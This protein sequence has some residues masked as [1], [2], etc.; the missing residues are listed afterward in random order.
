VGRVVVLGESLVVAPFAL[1]GAITFPADDPDS[2]RG[3]WEALPDDTSVVILSPAA[4]TAL[5]A[6]PAGRPD[7]LTV[8]MPP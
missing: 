3:R 5:G 8:T 7:L 4:A 2:V 1:A 6:L